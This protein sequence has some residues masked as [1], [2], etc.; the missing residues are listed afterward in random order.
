V[1]FTL[2]QPAPTPVP[3]ALSNGT[4]QYDLEVLSTQFQNIALRVEQ[5]AVQN[6]AVTLT[7]A[8]ANRNPGDI[9]FKSNVTGNDA[10]LLDSTWQQYLPTNVDA[11]LAQGIVPPGDVWGEDE[12]NRGTLRF[13]RPA[14]GDVLL[15]EM[16]GFPPVRLPLRADEPATVATVAD[17]PPSSEPRADVA[18][19]PTPTPRSGVAGAQDEAAQVLKSITHAL[20]TRDRSAY[21]AAF[22]P[23]LQA[24][25][26]AI[27]DRI[28]TLPLE[29]LAWEPDD[30]ATATLSDDGT[31]L[32]NYSI[33]LS[34]RVQDVDP[35]NVFVSMLTATLERHNGRWVIAAL[36]GEQP[37]WAYG[38]TAARRAGAFWIFY[39]PTMEAELPAIEE[40]AQR[41][42]D[43]VRETLPQRVQGTYVMYVTAA[44]D[45]FTELSGRSG[46]QFLGVAWSRY[47]LRKGGVEITNRAFYINGAAFRSDSGQDRQRTIAH[48]L[49]HLVLG[50]TTMPYTPAWVSEGAAMYVTSDFPTDTIQQW[51]RQEGPDTIDLAM[52]SGQTTF[53][54]HDADQTSIQYAYSALLAKYL[55]ETYGTQQ[56]FTFYDSFA[57]VPPNRLIE[58]LDADGSNFEAAM[59]NLAPTITAEKVQAAYNIDLQTLEREY[60]TW[61]GKQIP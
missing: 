37:F 59:S 13:P 24:E 52:L 33:E 50:D 31:T 47:L 61:L 5:V 36:H 15:L 23:E 56:F 49:T 7:V 60:E 32:N 22:A 28:G 6:D 30:A 29:A 27:F 20:E 26:G 4:Y 21:L 53:G 12:I 25:Q 17:L 44:D 54:G 42:L 40:E 11:A 10:V 45:E 55:I 41:A 14:D 46:A 43:T 3:V 1:K 16:P 2:D 35:Q 48:E 39:R 8:F 57:D 58:K 18:I 38:P 9:T 19:A 51:Y 34:H